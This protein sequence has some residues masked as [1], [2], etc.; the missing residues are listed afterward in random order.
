M[1]L[2]IVSGIQEEALRLK[3][4]PATAIVKQFWQDNMNALVTLCD[5]DD[6]KDDDDIISIH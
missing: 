6:K 2:N 4:N 1:L 5:K 3:D